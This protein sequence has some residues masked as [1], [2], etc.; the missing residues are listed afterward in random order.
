MSAYIEFCNVTLRYPLYNSRNLSLRHNLINIGTGGKLRAG[1]GQITQVTALENISFK[2]EKGD[3]VGLV[4]HNGAGKST[5]LRTMAGIYTPLEGRILRQGRIAT[6]LEVGAGM[7]PE[8]SGYDN[9]Y[10]MALMLGMTQ[11]EIESQIPDI[12]SFSGLGDFL[13]L[14]VRTYSAG[15]NMRLVFGVATAKSPDILLI[16]E[17]FGVGDEEFKD[18]A[19]QRMEDFIRGSQIFVLATHSHDLI[20][21][22]CN[23]VFELSHGSLIERPID[24]LN[25]ES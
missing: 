11:L 6:L 4:G 12:E 19:A 21:A 22:H 7:D 1:V 25:R 3:K 10:R 9:I 18:K 5:L 23:R 20:R 13:Q 2:L 8:L 16:D 17:V 24:F 15:M 14:P